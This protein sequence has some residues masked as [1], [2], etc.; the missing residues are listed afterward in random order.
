M[1]LPSLISAPCFLV[2]GARP[3]AE[4]FENLAL[5]EFTTRTSWF[6]PQEILMQATSEN[7]RLLSLSGA[8]NP[9]TE[10]K[11]GVIKKGAYADLLIYDANP[12]EN[13]DIIVNYKQHLK[14]IMKDGKIYKNEL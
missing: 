13:I 4:G 12:L 14:F 8:T 7:A 6:T 2:T 1:V 11:L 10:G 3:E 9:Y 5:T